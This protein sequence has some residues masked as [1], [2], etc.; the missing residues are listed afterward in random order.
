MNKP[1]LLYIEDDY[2]IVKDV[3]YFIE[4]FF[5]K[6]FIASDG[7]EAL[8]SYKNNKP[9]L[10]LLDINIPKINGIS[11]A[12]QIRKIDENI[13]IIFLTAYSDTTYLLSAIELRSFSY[14][15][16]PFNI[17]KLEE[18]II[19]SIKKYSIKEESLINLKNDF[20]WNKETSELYKNNKLIKLTKNEK[21]VTKF[22][23]K[24][25]G[26]YYTATTISET[27]FSDSNFL[28]EGQNIIQLISRLKIKLKKQLNSDSFFIETLYS[29]GYRIL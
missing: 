23:L 29:E 19:H 22:L 13:P 9:D 2:E 12:K 17:K 3:L 7:E 8:E 6:I 25:K 10:I 26:T 24:N 1:I 5:S 14:I 18:T 11:L 21:L 4:K 16:K 27:L 15:I 20:F 28:I